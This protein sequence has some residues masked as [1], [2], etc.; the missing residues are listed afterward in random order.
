[1]NKIKII[2]E[3][4]AINRRFEAKWFN[5]V[6]SSLKVV[7]KEVGGMVERLG[8][9]QVQQRLTTEFVN[10]GITK[11]VNDLWEEVGLFHANRTYRNLVREEKKLTLGFNQEWTQKIQD[12]L[13]MFLIEKVL[14]GASETTKNMLLK[15]ISE[16]IEQ[17][18]GIDR[19]VDELENY[20]GLRYQAARIVRTEVNRAANLGVKTGAESFPYEQNKV[21]ISVHDFRTRG[22]NPD[23][24]S[25]HL[26]MDGQTV[27]FD[28]KFTDP[29]SGAKLDFP[30]DPSAPPGDTV[31]CRCTMGIIGQRDDRRRLIPKSGISV[32]RNFNRPQTIIT[33]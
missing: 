10:N 5:T 23:D 13:R 21:W 26:R 27:P 33:I 1:M 9:E 19:I 32:I 16:G 14:F 25:D 20:P 31:N 28:S 22:A 7:G 24:H 30:G 2:R 18:W 6:W 3:Y 4:K 15:V 8:A 12:F 11:E 17:G 29:R